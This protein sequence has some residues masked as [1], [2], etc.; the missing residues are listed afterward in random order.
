MSQNDLESSILKSWE[1]PEHIR[2]RCQ[3]RVTDQD[4]FHFADLYEFI[5]QNATTAKVTIIDYGAGSSPYRSC[6]P[7]ADYRK[8]DIIAVPGL[9]YR[10]QPDS[11]VPERDET[12]D[13]VL[14]TQVAEH[15]FNP[16]T[17]FGECFRLLK[18]GG[19]L[20]LTTHG[21]WE[22]HGVPSDFQRWTEQGL[23]RDLR[24]AGF[25]EP[26]IYKV[27]CGLRAL[28]VLFTRTYFTAKPPVPWLPR[29]VFKLL[30]FTYSRL[31]PLIHR[32]GDK[33]WPHDRVVLATEGNATAPF[34]VVIA[35]VAEKLE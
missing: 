14:S 8:A 18:K 22:E 23:R 21:I 5:K 4:Y 15:L 1:S 20:V 31:F 24:R 33:Y 10:I 30:R 28:T 27:T 7:A 6:F 16:D 9:H 13:I 34:Y 12:F 11:T 17:Y 29:H 35:A 2:L 19:Q 25:K 26:N 32:W 3:S